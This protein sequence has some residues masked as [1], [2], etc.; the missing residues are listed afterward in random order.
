MN[1]KLKTKHLV[2]ILSTVLLAA[3]LPLGQC[4]AAAKKHSH[5]SSGG[6]GSSGP[7]G[8]MLSTPDPHT[9]VEH[10]N[11]GVELGSK[12]IWPDAIREHMAALEMDPWN[13]EFQQNLSGAHLRYG[14]DLMKR[15][16]YYDAAIQFRKALYVD[17]S[18]GPADE[19][20]DNCIQA[21][22][23]KANPSEYNYRRS[24]AEAA[25]EHQDY[26][27]AVVEWR[28]CVKMKD[29]GPTHA[30]LGYCLLKVGRDKETVEGFAELRTAVAKNWEYKNN[31]ELM[32]QLSA[33]HS[34]LGEILKDFAYKARERGSGTVGLKRL[35]NAGIEYRRAVEVNPA[36]T[37]AAR[38][39]LEVA[40]EAVAITPSFDN[41][42]MLGGAYLLIN[43]FE[44]AKM[45]YEECWK[46][47]P[48]RTE[49]PTAQKAYHLAVALYAKDSPAMLA[50]TVE[51]V[52]KAVQKDPKDAMWWYV[53]GRAR[54]T[55]YEKGGSQEDKDAALVAYQRAAEI[56]KYISPDLMQGLS[57]LSG[58]GG[59][60]VAAAP[61]GG[62]QPGKVPKK[63]NSAPAQPDK[64]DDTAR[65]ALAYGPIEKKLNSGDLE[66][67]Q[68]DLLSLVDHNPK[69]GRAW[70]LL[71]N[72]YEK[73]SD[74]DQAI[75]AYRQAS[76]LKEPGASDALDGISTSR[77][78]PLLADADKQ[79]SANN[80]VQ[81][82][83]SLR[84]AIS[85]APT[86]VM[87]YKKLAEVV[88]KMGDKGEADKLLAKAD[89]L[90]KEQSELSKK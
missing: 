78:A 45:E 67:A 4:Q 58:G 88:Q 84:E 82:A 83:A 73:K 77:I 61:A 62:Q 54:E 85:I 7:G 36:N 47:D 44:H 51:K 28:K 75:V 76:L 29:D 33:C 38:G 71:G 53:L 80:L 70:L 64:I 65:N 10:N 27:T 35:L 30:G 15:Q 90:E 3:S 72:T 37:E 11:R 25:D 60:E 50:N 32:R 48:R 86:K 40:R 2:A 16:K 13:K 26:E 19:A 49:L 74:L 39:L 87:L 59:T 21:G 20:L 52:T 5:R 63:G 17:P 46:S 56:N 66:G 24:L 68:K 8:V 23:K 6:G 57:R 9:A 41:H 22:N 81:A 69:D 79:L 12:G 42:L 1:P 14:Y 31:P 34:K 55:Q 43:D 18:N 89:K